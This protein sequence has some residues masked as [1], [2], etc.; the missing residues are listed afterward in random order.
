MGLIRNF[1][2]NVWSRICG[3]HRPIQQNSIFSAVGG[4]VIIYGGTFVM[5]IHL[6]G[7]LNL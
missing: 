1:F 3:Q 7:E 2:R 5:N 6:E 4:G